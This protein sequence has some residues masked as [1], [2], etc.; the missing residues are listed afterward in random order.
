MLATLV[1][2]LLPIHPPIP[3]SAA[4]NA[5]VLLGILKLSVRLMTYPTATSPERPPVN[6]SRCGQPCSL[7][8]CS[9]FPLRI[10]YMRSCRLTVA[11]L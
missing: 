6:R 7:S 9:T 4:A 2:Y 10:P 5:V 8:I 3:A 1:D 11:S